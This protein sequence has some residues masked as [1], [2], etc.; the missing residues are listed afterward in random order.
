MLHFPDE[1]ERR[2]IRRDLHDGLG[3]LL[4]SQAMTLEAIEEMI[5]SIEAQDKS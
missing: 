3:P 4:A 1:E 2:R 5:A